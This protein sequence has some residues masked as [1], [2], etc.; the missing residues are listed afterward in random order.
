MPNS[1]FLVLTL[2]SVSIF[3]Y[4]GLHGKQRNCI[5]LATTSRQLS[6]WARPQIKVNAGHVGS[7]RKWQILLLRQAWIRKGSKEHIWRWR[8]TCSL[9][10]RLIW[11]GGYTSLVC[12]RALLFKG[13]EQCTESFCSSSWSTWNGQVH[14][15][16]ASQ[17]YNFEFFR[18]L[19]M[20]MLN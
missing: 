5:T 4:I 15:L 6:R 8:H 13:D 10:R 1:I 9:W 18:W 14:F 7:R 2:S 20:V 11:D 16:Q 17:T 12:E 19:S 3:P